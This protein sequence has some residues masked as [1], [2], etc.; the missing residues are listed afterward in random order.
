MENEFE[1]IYKKTYSNTLRFIVINCYN[2]NELNDIIQDTYIEFYKLMK[3]NKKINT[4]NI[5]AFICGIAKNIIKRHY[6]KNKKIVHFQNINDDIRTEIPDEFD[7]EEN[8]I[9]KENIEQIWDYVKNKDYITSKIFYLYFGLGE[10]ISDIAKELKISESNV[11]NKIYRTIK[12]LKKV[13]GKE[14]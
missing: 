5:E 4:E 13:Y 10:K 6:S 7:L 14:E 3:R 1:N 2:I 8:F 11:K 12:E 9:N